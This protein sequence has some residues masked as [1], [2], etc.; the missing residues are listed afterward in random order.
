MRVRP[1]Q[2]L[3]P[4]LEE[5]SKRI[6]RNILNSD[7]GVFSELLQNSL[8]AV[9][10]RNKREGITYQPRPWITLD[11]RAGIIRIADNGLA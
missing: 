8:D 3:P 7:T 5:A 6:V 10:L 11:I 2:T 1:A 9:E 4:S